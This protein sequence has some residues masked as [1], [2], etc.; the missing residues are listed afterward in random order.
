MQNSENSLKLLWR[1][2]RQMDKDTEGVS[3]D[4]HFVG[5]KHKRIIQLV[6]KQNFPKN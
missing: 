4:H 5:P 1:K 6:H 2:K 3:Q